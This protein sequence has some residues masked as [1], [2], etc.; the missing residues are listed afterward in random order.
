[1][2]KQ[3]YPADPNSEIITWIN[4]CPN[5][6]LGLQIKA[7][8]HD[9]LKLRMLKRCLYPMFIAALFTVANMEAI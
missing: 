3:K 9:W 2:F 6:L 1:L 5:N 8:S 7:G 4:P